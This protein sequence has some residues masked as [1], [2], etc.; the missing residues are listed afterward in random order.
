[1]EILGPVAFQ[2]SLEIFRRFFFFLLHKNFL[3]KVFFVEIFWASLLI[4]NVRESFSGNKN[5][6]G[7]YWACSYFELRGYKIQSTYPLV[8]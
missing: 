5:R 3:K 2:K 8:D 4:W 7:H 6:P 1:M